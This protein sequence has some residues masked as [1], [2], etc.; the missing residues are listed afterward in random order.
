MGGV[1]KKAPSGLTCAVTQRAEA[2]LAYSG[3]LLV[4]LPRGKW[5]VVFS[6]RSYPGQGLGH[7]AVADAAMPSRVTTHLCSG[8]DPALL[9]IHG[10][11]GPQPQPCCGSGRA[12]EGEQEWGWVGDIRE[13]KQPH[14]LPL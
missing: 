5:Y 8:Q 1:S 12:P 6:C 13:A 11:E 4:P 10:E 14:A 9:W 3:S 2:Q 7:S